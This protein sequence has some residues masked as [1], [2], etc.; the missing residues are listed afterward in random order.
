MGASSSRSSVCSCFESLLSFPLFDL[1]VH[2]WPLFL[3]VYG[4]RFL[5]G[6]LPRCTRRSIGRS[7]TSSTSSKSGERWS[8]FVYFMFNP[9]RRKRWFVFFVVAHS[10]EILNP[11]VPMAL[12]LSGILMGINNLRSSDF[13]FFCYSYSGFDDSHLS[14]FLF[15]R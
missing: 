5:Q 9:W 3:F 1:A 10:E 13:F 2:Q 7:W 15:L 12:R 8:L 14:V 6:W 11:S 4:V